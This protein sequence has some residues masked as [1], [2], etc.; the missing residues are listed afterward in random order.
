ME[1]SY[2]QQSQDGNGAAPGMYGNGYAEGRIHISLTSHRH[3]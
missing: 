2:H 3:V 1:G